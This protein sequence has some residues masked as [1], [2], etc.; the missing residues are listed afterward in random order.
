MVNDTRPFLFTTGF[1]PYWE[2]YPGPHV[3]VPFEIVGIEDDDAVQI[4]SNA[5][6]LTK[7]NWN[8]AAAVT[9][10]SVTLFFARE[11][12]KHHGRSTL[13]HRTRVFVSLL[14]TGRASRI[15]SLDRKAASSWHE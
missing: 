3:P 8:T 4:A 11:V 12:G 7:M 10:Q 6:A 5:L 15:E 9:A 2:T 14:Y 1:V 13:Y